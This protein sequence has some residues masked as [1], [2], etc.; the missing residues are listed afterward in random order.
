M[1]LRDDEIA[2]YNGAANGADPVQ[3]Q[4]L[5]ADRSK[6]VGL[7]EQKVLGSDQLKSLKTA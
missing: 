3:L 4:A 7:L 5:L 2:K 1:S 6:R